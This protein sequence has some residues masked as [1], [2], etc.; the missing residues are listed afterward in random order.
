MKTSGSLVVSDPKLD[1]QQQG[2]KERNVLFNDALN[3]F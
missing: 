1:T 2:T 3:T